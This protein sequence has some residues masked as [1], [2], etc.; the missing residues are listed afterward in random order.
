[1]SSCN[2]QVEFLNFNKHVN[3][4]PVREV[5]IEVEQFLQTIVIFLVLFVNKEYL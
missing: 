2:A 1:M 5:H 4:S 3:I